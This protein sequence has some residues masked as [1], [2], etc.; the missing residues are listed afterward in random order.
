LQHEDKNDIQARLFPTVKL[1]FCAVRHHGCVMTWSGVG[2]EVAKSYQAPPILALSWAGV[3]AAGFIQL[4]GDGS[5]RKNLNTKS[6]DEGHR[7]QE[8]FW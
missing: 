8:E 4:L 5:P 6:G 1:G 2:G 7:L 3:S